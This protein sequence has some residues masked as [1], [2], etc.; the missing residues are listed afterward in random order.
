M[1]LA[2]NYTHIRLICFIITNL[3]QIKFLHEFV[4]VL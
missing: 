3:K 4:L 1:K 2:M